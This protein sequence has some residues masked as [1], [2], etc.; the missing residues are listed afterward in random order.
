MRTLPST[1]NRWEIADEDGWT[2]AHE[3]AKYERLPVDFSQW[4]LA[5]DS[6][7]TVAHMATLWGALPESFDQWGLANSRGTTVLH[8]L[9]TQIGVGADLLLRFNT[10]WCKE[11]PLCKTS[12]DWEAFKKELP[13]IHMRYSI[14]ESMECDLTPILL[15]PII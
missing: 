2:V 15:H 9:L 7:W 8:Y 13:E 12:D 3:A 10:I 5:D 14:G 11:K 4:G 6:G 1:F